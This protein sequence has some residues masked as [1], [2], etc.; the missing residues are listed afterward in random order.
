MTL[1]CMRHYFAVCSHLERV[2][3]PQRQVAQEQEGDE[4]SAGLLVDVAG[5][6]GAPSQPLEDEER[7]QAALEEADDG[8]DDGD[9][10]DGAVLGDAADGGH[11]GEGVVEEDAAQRNHQQ[12]RVER[13]VE[14]REPQH[15][16]LTGT[17]R[18]CFCVLS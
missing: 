18:K 4:R 12:R 15:A 16:H 9:D 11:G 3:D 7:L 1:C 10:A 17:W 5:V 6:L 8:R 13:V 2:D 14:G